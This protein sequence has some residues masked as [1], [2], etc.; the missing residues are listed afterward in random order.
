MKRLQLD[1]DRIV[2]LFSQKM[3]NETYL[4]TFVTALSTNYFEESVQMKLQEFDF[5]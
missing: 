1:K 2:K 4:P 5:V 3:K